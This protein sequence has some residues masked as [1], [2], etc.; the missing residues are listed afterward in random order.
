MP[1]ETHSHTPSI[2]SPWGRLELTR[3]DDIDLPAG[4]V[5]HLRAD[6]RARA[7]RAAQFM[8]FAALTGYYDLVRAQEHVREPRHEL[9]EEEA[10]ALSRAI[11]HLHKGDLVRITFY[12]QDCY[13]TRVGVVELLDTAMRCLQVG[14]HRI[15]FGDIWRLTLCPATET[16]RADRPSMAVQAK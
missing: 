7:N 11:A 10:D 9:T 15:A 14:G 8:P 16:D 12:R 1:D 2:P 13:L 4:R 3:A 5:C 6:G